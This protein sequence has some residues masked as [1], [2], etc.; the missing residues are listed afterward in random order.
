MT[1]DIKNYY[2]DNGD[3]ACGFVLKSGEVIQVTNHAENKKT[4]FEIDE[5]D[6]NEHADQIAATWHTHPATNCNLSVEDYACF[7]AF[8]DWLHYIYDGH[9]LA[10]YTVNQETGYVLVK[11]IQIL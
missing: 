9:R 1:S 10:C 2:V 6:L 11:E 7:V 8:P 3:E 4:D 5:A